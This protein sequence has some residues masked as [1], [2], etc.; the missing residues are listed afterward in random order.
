MVAPDNDSFAV[1]TM[2]VTLLFVTCAYEQHDTNKT[3]KPRILLIINFIISF[4]LQVQIKRIIYDLSI[5]CVNILLG[6]C[7][8]PIAALTQNEK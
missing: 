1:F 5:F 7:I 2:P 6:N 3:K 8:G 4:V